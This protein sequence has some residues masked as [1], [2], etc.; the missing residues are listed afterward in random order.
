MSNSLLLYTPLMDTVPQPAP[1]I[2][3]HLPPDQYQL[4]CPL[5][6]PIMPAKIHT[7]P[8]I[9]TST[10]GCQNKLHFLPMDSSPKAILLL[11]DQDHPLH[12]YRSKQIFPKICNPVLMAALQILAIKP[13][14]FPLST[15]PQEESSCH[16]H[17]NPDLSACHIHRLVHQLQP[18]TCNPTFHPMP[19]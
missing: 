2:S 16:P 13:Q 8:H 11:Q 6:R 3:Q 18:E 12:Q 7:Q 19:T 15:I 1:A 9:P 10:N 14:I 5:L 17:L 4:V